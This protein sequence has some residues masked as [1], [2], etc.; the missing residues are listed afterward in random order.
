MKIYYDTAPIIMFISLKD[1]SH[2]YSPFNQ[3]IDP[4]ISF[5]TLEEALHVLFS[6]K[7]YKYWYPNI[8]KRDAYEIFVQDLLKTCNIL[9]EDINSYNLVLKLLDNIKILND[10]YNYINK[11]K[12]YSNLPGFMDL[13]HFILADEF[14]EIFVT[15]DKAFEK[16]KEIRTKNLKK[17]VLLDEKDLKLIDEIPLRR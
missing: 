1:R 12:P 10:N 7:A 16:I 4:Y 15:T 14:C 8:E 9:E 5:I 3:D 2:E 17:I 13:I 6:K 11:I